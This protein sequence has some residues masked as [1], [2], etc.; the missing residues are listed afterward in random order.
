LAG[1]AC[2]FLSPGFS[3]TTRD[4]TAIFGFVGA[5]SAAVALPAHDLM[6]DIYAHGNIED[7]AR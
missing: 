1:S 4:F 5:L 2:A 7:I 6:Q 3:A